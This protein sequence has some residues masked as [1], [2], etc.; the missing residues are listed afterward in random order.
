MTIDEAHHEVD[1]AWRTSYGPERN[2]QVIDVLTAQSL[3][4]GA[5]HF[6]MR[7]FFRGIYVP[8]M[9]K[10]AWLNLIFQNRKSIFKLLRNGIAKYRDATR[11]QRLVPEPGWRDAD[12]L[13]S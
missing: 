9:T 8:Q 10:R 6:L 13:Q 2:K 3:N 11:Q 5:M 4:I 1:K 12:R 7:L